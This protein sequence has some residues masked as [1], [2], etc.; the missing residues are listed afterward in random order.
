[1][2][3]R[4][5]LTAAVALALLAVSPSIGVAQAP[6]LITVE[7]FNAPLSQVIRGFATYS[8]STIVVARDVGDPEVTGTIHNLDWRLGLDRIL[9]T[10]ALIARPDLS[11]GIRIE[12]RRRVTVEFHNAP[13]SRVIRGFATYSGS[14]IVVANDV[15][16]PEVTGTINNDDWRLGMDRILETYALVARLDPTGIVR[17]ERRNPA[18][19]RPPGRTR[20]ESR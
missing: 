9:E 16:D 2:T 3:K 15:G 7:V 17:I 20:A 19:V 14:T 13:L 4:P 1:M 10:H 6:R 5:R 12:R 8:G 11:G 18:P